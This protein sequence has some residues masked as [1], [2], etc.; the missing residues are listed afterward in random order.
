MYRLAKISVWIAIASVLLEI[1]VVL[2]MIWTNEW[3]AQA[4]LASK[5]LALFFVSSCLI[6]SVVRTVMPWPPSGRES[7]VE[8][9]AKEFWTFR[10][11]VDLA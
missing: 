6:L 10:R 7:E 1:P 8:R 5:T 4:A 3:S 9:R 2:G 11:A